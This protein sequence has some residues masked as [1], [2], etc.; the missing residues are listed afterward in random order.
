MLKK[1]Y[2]LPLKIKTKKNKYAG[3]Y[4]SHR[5]NVSFL[6]RK[7]STKYQ[8]KL[9]VEQGEGAS[10]QSV[11]PR[12]M[13]QGG[14]NLQQQSQGPCGEVSSLSCRRLSTPDF[15]LRNICVGGGSHLSD[16]SSSLS[17]PLHPPKIT[18]KHP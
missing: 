15:R 14:W 10:F 16:L 5:K 3:T 4:Q 7:I 18:Q 8:K 17:H 11:R 9:K 2:Q 1:N 13:A 12:Q 6:N